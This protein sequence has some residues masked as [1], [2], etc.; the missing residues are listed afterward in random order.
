MGHLQQLNI[1]DFETEQVVGYRMEGGESFFGS[2][3]KDKYKEL[4][5]RSTG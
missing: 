4:L 3:G 5:C 2:P 1:L